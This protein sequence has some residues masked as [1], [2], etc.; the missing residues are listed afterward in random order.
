MSS[1]PNDP[2]R[3]PSRTTLGNTNR[4]AR[5]DSWGAGTITALILGAL[6]V[7]GG[8]WYAVSDHSSS[9]ALNPP[10]TTAGQSGGTNVNPGSGGQN[11]PNPTRPGGAP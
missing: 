8:I 4:P 9:T 5:R 6:I 2:V 11:V 3:D 10:A 7:L 1:N